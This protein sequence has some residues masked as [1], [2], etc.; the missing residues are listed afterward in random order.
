[1][2]NRF[3]TVTATASLL[4]AS[5][6][7]FDASAQTYSKTVVAGGVLAFAHYAGVNPD[8]SSKGKTTVR[9]PSAPAHGIVRLRE[10]WGSAS[11]GLPALQSAG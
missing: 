7:G 5:L 9:L 10:G 8:C 3:Q 11:P 6:I 2:A 1:M 4:L